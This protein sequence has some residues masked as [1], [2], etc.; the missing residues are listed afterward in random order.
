MRYATAFLLLVFFTLFLLLPVYTVIEQGLNA[1]MILEIFRSSIYVEGMLNSFAIAVVTTAMV[2]LI[3]MPLA[4]A[5]DKF[6]FPGKKLS[7]I[8]IMLPMILPPFVGALGFQHILGNYGVFNTILVA[9]GL[10]AFDWLGGHGRFW[11]VCLIEA[12]HLYPI[13]Y[14]NLVTAF[15][16]IDP[17]MGEAG[18]NMGASRW[19]R[20]RRITLPLLKPGMLAGGSIVLIWSF[21]ELGT[22][23]MFGYNRVT[24]VQIFNGI[25][26]LETNPLPYSL[27]LIMLVISAGLYMLSRFAFGGSA[28]VSVT[29]GGMGSSAITIPGWKKYLPLALL[30]G[31]TFCATMPHVALILTA[32]SKDWYGTIVPHAYSMMHFE[33]ALSDKM[34]VPSILNSLTYSG[35]AMLFA[36]VAG[37]MTALLVVRWKIRGAILFD[38][39]SMLPLAVPGII[40]AFGYLSLSVRFEWAR[41]I[42]NPITNPT[43]LLAAAYAVR[44]LPYV[45]RAAAAGLE[46]TPVELEE[47]AKN[48]GAGSFMTIRRITVPLI[49]ANIIVGALFA[50]SFSMLE[51]SDSLILAQKSAFFPITRAIFE[52]S[53]ILGSGPYIACAFGVWA[54]LFLAFTL[55]AATILLGKKMGALFRL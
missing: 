18:M 53:Q 26:E 13:L 48:L 37:F 23:L 30:L 25:T 35:I 11:S 10:P 2:F 20:F 16:N 7:N 33:N 43:L 46:Q 22:P 39:L 1:R 4:I 49:S 55:G 38:M 6:E 28:A 8:L 24:T 54:M 9:A 52:L 29:K 47:A 12:L 3:A 41:E 34:V 15:A 5:Y 44:R 45:V 51:V 17:S 14:L 42:M 19:R 32:F 27:V 31:I 50:F 36:V 40:M 21:T